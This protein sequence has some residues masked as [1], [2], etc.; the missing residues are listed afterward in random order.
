VLYVTGYRFVPRVFV[1]LFAYFFGVCFLLFHGQEG[2]LPEMRSRPLW[3]GVTLLCAI[4]LCILTWWQAFVQGEMDYRILERSE[5]EKRYIQKVLA[6]VG[7]KGAVRDPLLVLMN[8]V[9]GLGAEYVHP[10][11][12]LSDFTDLE[13]FPAG[14]SVNTPA[15]VSILRDMGLED[16]WDFLEWTLDNPKPLLVLISRS[17]TETWRW[18]ALWESYFSRRVA[19]NR[20]ARLVPVHDFRNRQG[21]GLVFFSMRSAN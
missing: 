9:S 19:P 11:K 2:T 16:G 6:A 1:P 7:S 5:L 13:I 8:P 10:L 12:E 21:A 18:K 15:Y 20:R 14:W 17:G 3:K 4:A